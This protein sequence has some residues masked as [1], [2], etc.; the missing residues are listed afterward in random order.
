MVSATI[1]KT[2]RWSI[3]GIRR[4][5]PG[6]GHIPGAGAV[7]V[8]APDDLS[9]I[10]ELRAALGVSALTA[11]V[12]AARGYADAETAKRFLQPSAAD[13]IDPFY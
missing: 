12:L 4:I 3:D 6:P 10:Q 8:P 1:E 5:A 9:T 2:L 11:R 13:L 7:A